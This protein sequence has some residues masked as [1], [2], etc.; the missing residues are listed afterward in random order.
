MVAFAG[1]LLA[2]AAWLTES[3]MDTYVDKHLQMYR[4]IMN[5]ENFIF[6]VFIL[7]GSFAFY[8]RLIVR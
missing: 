1:E 2:V 4:Y 6:F 3:E 5:Q 7:P 8:L